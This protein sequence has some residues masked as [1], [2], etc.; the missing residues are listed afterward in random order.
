MDQTVRRHRGVSQTSA[1]HVGAGIPTSRSASHAGRRVSYN[2][3]GDPAESP[4]SAIHAGHPC[5]GRSCTGL[6]GWAWP[7]ALT[8]AGQPAPSGAGCRSADKLR[9][10]AA[11]AR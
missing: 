9:R 11:F 3:D 7:W 4:R 8:V 10:F 5:S 2:I 1:D 6:G